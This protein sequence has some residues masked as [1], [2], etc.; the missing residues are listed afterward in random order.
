MAFKVQVGPPQIAIHQGQTVLVT[1]PD[2]Q[3]TWPSEKGLYFL[4]TRI[5]SNWAIYANGELWEL[6]NGGPISYYAARIFL[7]NKSILTED[8]P[9]PPRT[10]GLTISRSISGGLH[11]DLDITNNS[12]KPVRFQLEVAFRCDFSDVFEVKSGHIVRR[13]QIT[14]VW[15]ERRQ[16]LRTAYSNRDFHRAVTTSVGRAARKA[17]SA[18]GRLSFEVALQPNEA[19]HAC[20]LYTLEDGE[21]PMHAPH[22]CAGSCGRWRAEGRESRR[23]YAR[24]LIPR[25]S[26]RI[27]ALMAAFSPQECANY[28]RHAGYAST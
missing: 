21:Q 6:L 23:G 19:W 15:S 27:G 16:Q 12:M 26:R 22:Y 13:G 5:I 28:F 3:I 1:D 8:G 7:T 9:I 25:L 18:N 24:V 20:L 11:E 10:L 2:G 14:T 4:D 17:V